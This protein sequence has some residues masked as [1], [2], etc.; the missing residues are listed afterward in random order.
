MRNKS[1]KLFLAEARSRAEDAKAASPQKKTLCAP[2][3]PWRLCEEVESGK[4]EIPAEGGKN[5]FPL[6][7]D[8]TLLSHDNTLLPHGKTPPRDGETN[9]P[10]E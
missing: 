9:V 7:T 4:L 3:V 8:K 2:C 10:T 1:G 5:N 6:S